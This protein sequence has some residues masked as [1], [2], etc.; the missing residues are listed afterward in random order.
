VHWGRRAETL[1][2]LDTL[3]GGDGRG[4]EQVLRAA[5]AW[6]LSE[7]T[8]D[9]VAAAAAR[10]RGGGRGEPGDFADEI[11][12]LRAAASDFPGTAAST[13]RSS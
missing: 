11:A 2:R 8:P 7:A 6:A 3:S 12:V 13:S 1:D 5:L 10:C 9:D 4:D